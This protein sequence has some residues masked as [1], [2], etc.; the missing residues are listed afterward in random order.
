MKSE[1]TG[2]HFSRLR[3]ALNQIEPNFPGGRPALLPR[4]G[5]AA[6]E[7]AGAMAACKAVTQPSQTGRGGSHRC[8]LTRRIEYFR[9]LAPSLANTRKTERLG[10]QAHPCEAPPHGRPKARFLPLYGTNRGCFSIGKWPWSGI[11][12]PWIGRSMGWKQKSMG[13]I[14]RSA[15]WTDEKFAGRRA[16]ACVRFNAVPYSA[17]GLRRC[18]RPVAP[19]EKRGATFRNGA[20]LHGIYIEMKKL[21]PAVA[22]AARRPGLWLFYVQM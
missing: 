19:A 9:A 17:Q 15:A 12:I 8:F 6:G 13:W 10:F 2:L 4:V 16:E 21:F 1:S 20:P 5:H 3:H 14:G 22:A 11:S 7:D 18:R